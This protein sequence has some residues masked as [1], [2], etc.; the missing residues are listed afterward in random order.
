[1]RASSVDAGG[2]AAAR[3]LLRQR[4]EHQQAVLRDFFAL[5]T[6]TARLREQLVAA[7]TAEQVALGNLVAATDVATAAKL[8][9]CSQHQARLAG[10][11]RRGDVAPAATDVGGADTAADR[12][13]RSG[14]SDG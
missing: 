7:E 9:G 12:G 13:R 10:A 5:G 2:A 4:H 11:A 1:M 14:E 8:T 3:E 6:K